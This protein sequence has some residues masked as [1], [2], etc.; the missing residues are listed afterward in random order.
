MATTVDELSAELQSMQLAEEVLQSEIQKARVV[1]LNKRDTLKVSIG[2][3]NMTQS[4]FGQVL[5]SFKSVFE[6]LSV[7][8]NK[9]TFTDA[10]KGV[11]DK[12]LGLVKL[13]PKDGDNT[14]RFVLLDFVFEHCLLHLNFAFV[15]S[16]KSLKNYTALADIV[17]D[18]VCE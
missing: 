7:I 8:V 17:N 2:T 10:S 5:E 12:L 13:I 11:C 15:L 14:N 18:L 6:R 9:R 4:K 16:K 3:G 1:V